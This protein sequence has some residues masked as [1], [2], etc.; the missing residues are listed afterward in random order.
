MRF[1][2]E[3]KGN[4]KMAQSSSIVVTLRQHLF[5]RNLTSLTLPHSPSLPSFS[6]SLRTTPHT[7]LSLSASFSS[8]TSMAHTSLPSA[9]AGMDAVQRRL[10]FE[11]ESVPLLIHSFFNYFFFAWFLSVFV[12]RVSC[13]FVDSLIDWSIDLRFG[14]WEWKC[15]SACFVGLFISR[16]TNSF[17]F[18][19]L[20][21]SVVGLQLYVMSAFARVDCNVFRI[22]W[23]RCS[24]MA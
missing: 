14:C 22:F 20:K 6:F 23:L 8:H 11:D 10:M 15:V 9:D 16:S 2:K 13:G 21:F 4:Q 7:P 1:R 3:R 19:F 12:I 5:K 18:I 24:I 17:I